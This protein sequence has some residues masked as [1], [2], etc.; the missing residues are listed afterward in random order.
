MKLVFALFSTLLLEASK[1]WLRGCVGSRYQWFSL[2]TLRQISWN[3]GHNY[4]IIIIT[5]EFHKFWCIFNI[6]NNISKIDPKRTLFG[7]E[8]PNP[9]ER[10]NGTDL[11]RASGAS[12]RRRW[13][14]G[15]DHR[16]TG[17]REAGR[18]DFFVP[19]VQPSR[20]SYDADLLAWSVGDLVI[21]ALEAL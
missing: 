1:V 14:N 5:N 21:T 9:A 20:G 3:I 4:A 15:G 10:P 6:R 16:P 19:R 2:P 13:T 7:P 8:G 12:T 18:P 11:Q 17:I